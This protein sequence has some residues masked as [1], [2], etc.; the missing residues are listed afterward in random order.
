M[1]LRRIQENCFRDAR[2]SRARHTCEKLFLGVVEKRVVW[3]SQKTSFSGI[4]FF[5]VDLVESGQS[6]VCR[7]FD[8]R[9]FGTKFVGIEA[10]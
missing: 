2:V 3:G 8:A 10:L 5:Y 7:A 1:G 6:N 9:N 4:T